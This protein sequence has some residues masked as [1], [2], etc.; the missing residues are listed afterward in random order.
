M[1]KISI[2]LHYKSLSIYIINRREAAKN[3]NYILTSGF[4]KGFF[5][6]KDFLRIFCENSQDLNSQ[7]SKTKKKG[8]DHTRVP[9]SRGSA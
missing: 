4:L 3:L 2:Y 9:E 7:I 1:F 6:L 8:M 5:F